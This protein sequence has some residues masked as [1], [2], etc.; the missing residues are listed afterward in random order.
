MA[1]TQTELSAITANLDATDIELPPANQ[2][3]TSDAELPDLQSAGINPKDLNLSGIELASKRF[4][5]PVAP[6]EP[7]TGELYIPETLREL[8]SQQ[9]VLAIALN[10]IAQ[11]NPGDDSAA[12]RVGPQ[13]G[14]AVV[15][16]E[17]DKLIEI[18]WNQDDDLGS[19][20]MNIYTIGDT[21]PQET[22]EFSFIR[23]DL[24]HRDNEF[25]SSN[26]SDLLRLEAGNNTFNNEASNDLLKDTMVRLLSDASYSPHL[27]NLEHQRDV[28]ATLIDDQS[29]YGGENSPAQISIE[30]AKL[31]LPDGNT[32]DLKITAKYAQV[33][34]QNQDP[35]LD[36]TSYH[37]HPMIEIHTSD[38]QLLATVV[39]TQPFSLTP[40]TDPNPEDSVELRND[41][42]G[43]MLPDIVK[44]ENS[45]LAQSLFPVGNQ[46]AHWDIVN[47][48]LQETVSHRGLTLVNGGEIE[49]RRIMNNLRF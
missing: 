23:G 4:E 47:K 2:T 13:G 44:V 48:L 25:D 8:G 14:T 31:G 46:Q 38:G 39:Y 12:V 30:S 42:P 36:S 19:A 49:E 6:T 34:E 11:L 22:H 35:K 20:T 1:T 45:S 27:N 5:P 37:E 24:D 3:I 41:I 15:A 21:T 32:Y 26:T 9:N 40:K 43:L 7:L 18:L 16:A 10:T 29:P 28:I 17:N 33:H